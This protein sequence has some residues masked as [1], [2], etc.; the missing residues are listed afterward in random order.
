[1]HFSDGHLATL[2]SAA[3]RAAYS[4]I[5]PDAREASEATSAAKTAI[6]DM[7][8][9]VGIVRRISGIYRPGW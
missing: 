8:R 1:V 3:I 9:D 7:R 6:R 4:P 5:E 2:T